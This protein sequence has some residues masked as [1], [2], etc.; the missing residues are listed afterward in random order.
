MFFVELWLYTHNHITSVSWTGIPKTR[1]F[2]VTNES[3]TELSMLYKS[4]TVCYMY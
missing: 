2:D 4:E 3:Q 1:G